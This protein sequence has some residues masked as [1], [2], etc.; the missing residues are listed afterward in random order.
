MSQPA[1]A[2][3]Q[4]GLHRAIVDPT[5]ED[6]LPADPRAYFGAGL[7][8]ATAA[9]LAAVPP[10]RHLVYR[11]LIRRQLHAVLHDF[12]PRTRALRGEA[13]FAADADAWIEAPGPRSR[14][15]R[16]LPAEFVAA[17]RWTDPPWLHDLARHE[18]LRHEVAAAPPREA[19]PPRPFA[20]DARLAFD[21]SARL[22]RYDFAVHELSEQPGPDAPPR[23]EPTALL[24]YRDREHEV[25]FLHLSPLAEALVDALLG[26]ATVEAAVRRAAERTGASLD[27]D[28]LGR[29][30]VLLADLADRGAVLGAA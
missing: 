8:D 24:A 19:A 5:V 12:L 20:L 3:I 21:A 26:G 4:R 13:P 22:V 18:L 9:W 25:R 27:G 30:S 23:R 15:L 7:D 6:A 16:D 1:L 10:E 14:I 2:D 17:A 28:L 29:V 11:H